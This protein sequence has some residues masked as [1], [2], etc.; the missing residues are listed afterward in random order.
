MCYISKEP[1]R[2]NKWWVQELEME[3]HLKNDDTSF[4]GFVREFGG[5]CL[6]FYILEILFL[7]LFWQ[8]ATELWQRHGWFQRFL[9]VAL[10]ITLPI[11]GGILAGLRH[12]V[13]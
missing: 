4:R 8:E 2:R 11:F 6:P 13:K 7:C 10:S 3:K 1:D 9:D 12:S 5:W